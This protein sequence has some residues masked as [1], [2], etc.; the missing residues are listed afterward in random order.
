[1]SLYLQPIGMAAVL[2][3]LKYH[4]PHGSALIPNSI[5]KQ[6]FPP[7]SLAGRGIG[8]S[9]TGL[10]RC[11]RRSIMRRNLCEY[12]RGQSA[13]IDSGVLAASFNIRS[14]ASVS[15]IA[16][17]LK[18][19]TPK[20]GGRS[21]LVKGNVL[22]RKRAADRFLVFTPG[23]TPNPHRSSSSPQHPR[24]T[25]RSA[26]S[27]QTEP[28]AL[29]N[30]LLPPGHSVK[31][32]KERN[33]R[34]TPPC[35]LR[36]RGMASEGD[37]RPLQLIFP[38]PISSHH[39]QPNRGKYFRLAKRSDYAVVE[40]QRN[41]GLSRKQSSMV[42]NPAFAANRSGAIPTYARRSGISRDRTGFT[43]VQT[44]SGVTMKSIVTR[45]SGTTNG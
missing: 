21:K 32:E 8:F 41:D 26:H 17:P 23:P 10:F 18:L 15:P 27:P 14:T 7:I 30:F 24:S 3:A 13:S 25:S 42:R 34:E 20:C 29:N 28:D 12:A 16:R 36:L 22:Q 43:L 1:M 35:N 4:L 39:L 40:P 6:C 31:R 44:L 5:L 37:R 19:A 33:H 9:P 38:F 2:I 45:C 11:I